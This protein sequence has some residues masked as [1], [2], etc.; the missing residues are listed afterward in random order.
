[1]IRYDQ[2]PQ[3]KKKGIKETS[4]GISALVDVIKEWEENDGLKINPDFQRGH[5]WTENQQIKFIE[6]LLRGGQSG[7]EIYFNDPCI[8]L[9][10]K[11]YEDLE[12][13]EYSDFVCVDGLQRITAI[14]K[15]V[16]NE[17]KVFQKYYYKDFQKSIILEP[18]ITVHTNNLK[19]KQE[20]LEWYLEMNEGGVVHSS[21]EILRIKDMLH[22]ELK[23]SAKHFSERRSL[24]DILNIS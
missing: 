10:Y 13:K 9:E 16:N 8:D 4:W 1:M 17:I 15:F 14:Q 3:F 2:I 7:K 22:E 12:C 11:K 18:R 20:V 23:K 21:Q 6:F 5:V 19:T 24:E